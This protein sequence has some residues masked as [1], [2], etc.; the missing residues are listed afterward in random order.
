M[1]TINELD[2]LLR[3]RFNVS[4]DEFVAALKTLPSVRPWA[5]TLSEDQARLLDHA[6]FRE[7]P[8][9]Y[10]T[11]GAEIAGHMGR[12]TS[13]AHTSGEVKNILGISDSWV[14]QKRLAREL[15]VIPTGRSWLFPA[16][17]FETDPTTHLP[18]RQVRGLAEV[19]QALP[20]DLHPTAVDGF[21]HTPQPELSRGGHEQAPLDWLRDGGN[22]DAVIAAVI[23][24][25][26]HSR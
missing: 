11:A 19:F 17:Q 3:E 8:P 6:D 18:F 22:V 9:A 7:D 25:D 2:Q 24:S 14:R 15:W 13:T 12:L 23:A 1:G 26:W 10:L 5:T 21:L 20:A 16:S 4:R